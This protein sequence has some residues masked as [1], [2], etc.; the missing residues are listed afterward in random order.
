[1]T[2]VNKG[3][4]L[5]TFPANVFGSGPSTVTKSGLT[6]T[7]SLDYR[8]LVAETSSVDTASLTTVQNPTTG[9][10]YK[11]TLANLLASNQPLDATLTALAALDST[12]GLVEQ[13]GAD[14]F[15]KRPIGAAADNNIPTRLDADLRYFLRTDTVPATAGGTGLASFAVGDI[16]FADTT[17]TLAKLADV[18]TGNALISGGVGTAP[19]WGKIGLTTH[20]S[21]TLGVAN[22]G[23][24]IATATAY[25]VLCGGTTGTGAL[26]SVA[27]VGSSGQVLTSNGAGALPTFQTPSASP[28]VG[29]CILALSGGNLVL[30]PINGNLLSINGTN[31]TVPSA[32]VSVTPSGLTP[33]TTYFIYAYMNAGTMT[34]EASTTGHSTDTSTGVEIKTGD[35]TRTLVGMGDCVAG[36]AWAPDDSTRIGCLSWFNRRPKSAYTTISANQTITGTSFADVTAFQTSFLCWNDCA[37]KAVGQ[38]P[39]AVSGAAAGNAIITYDGNH[40]APG[41]TG[42]STT[43]SVPLGLSGSMTLS[44]GAHVGSIYAMR[45]GGTNFTLFGTG[46]DRCSLTIEVMG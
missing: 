13:T 41:Y 23:T 8:I 17:T 21:G 6:Y 12:A 22:G 26:Q 31:Q 5:P 46:N 2:T 36:P 18:A 1:M 10:F 28:A 3:R 43:A 16:L 37:T 15:T 14:T 29:Q 30:S 7:F 42:I 40:F 33:S 20:V 34:L 11:I 45:T 19:E 27:S 32:G 38:G 9:S 24:G 44:E 4:F 35:A 39:C 25:A